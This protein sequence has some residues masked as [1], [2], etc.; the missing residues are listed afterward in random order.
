MDLER[1]LPLSARELQTL[2]LAVC[3]CCRCKLDSRSSRSRGAAKPWCARRDHRPPDSRLRPGRTLAHSS[4][5]AGWL[6]SSLFNGQILFIL[7]ILVTATTTIL[8]SILTGQLKWQKCATKHM[9]TQRDPAIKLENSIGSRW[10]FNSKQTKQVPESF[11]GVSARVGR[12]PI[13]LRLRPPPLS[14]GGRDF[15]GSSKFELNSIQAN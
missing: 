11:H 12:L 4:K 7:I 15:I 1:R 2:P 5:P 14:Q 6:G 8:V 13:Q 3:R 9:L 10:A